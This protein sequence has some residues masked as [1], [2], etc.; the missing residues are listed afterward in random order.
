MDCKG[1]ALALLFTMNL[2]RGGGSEGSVEG[3]IRGLLTC[4]TSLD[5][6]PPLALSTCVCA[7]AATAP[8]K[9]I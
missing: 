9:T 8:R 4:R 6:S 5:I 2:V 3:N 1:D 7:P